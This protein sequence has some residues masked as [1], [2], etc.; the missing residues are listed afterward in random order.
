MRQFGV[1][2]KTAW[3]VKHKLLK[4]MRL[5]EEPRRLDGRVEIDDAYLGGERA[6]ST[7]GGWG[8]LRKSAFEFAYRFNRRFDLP[9]MLPRLLHAAVATRPLP[10]RD[11]QWYEAGS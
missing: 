2:Y 1:T 11:L 9:A 5:R 10:L 3:L 6:G 7:N 8:A 4:T